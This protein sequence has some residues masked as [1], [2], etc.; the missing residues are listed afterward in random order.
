MTILLFY[1][2]GDE[3]DSQRWKKAFQLADST[4]DFRI[5][6]N[7][8]DPSD[9]PAYCFVWQADKDI[10]GNQSNIQAIF[11]MG[12]GMDG[13]LR[14]QSLPPDIPVY[15]LAD[16]ELGKDMADYMTM[17]CL[18]LHRRM[19]EFLSQQAKQLWKRQGNK[20]ASEVSVG[21]L[22]YG[23][24]GQ[25]VAKQVSAIGYPMRGWTRTQKSLDDG[26]ELFHGDDQL[27]AFLAGTDILIGL[28]PHTSATDGLLSAERL[29]QLPK[30]ASIIN[31]GRGSLVKLDDLSAALDTH[32][33]AAI[34]D[35]MPNEP[36]ASDHPIWRRSDVII[37]PHVSALTRPQ[38]AAGYVAATI[39]RIHSGDKTAPQLDR[40]R[41]Y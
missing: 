12:A 7:W 34:L 35:V 40:S 27:G 33:S 14:D 10:I 36:L 19:P 41:G 39:N 16:D 15:R 37:T 13:V 11:S 26:S 1:P 6:P 24:L 28:L 22:G 18:M 9:G 20:R 17:A 2:D 5:W 31:A 8:G 4:I 32:L 25:A 38:S 30:G 3:A 23:R 21:I 29:T